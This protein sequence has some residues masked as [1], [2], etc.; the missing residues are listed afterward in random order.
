M[1]EQEAVKALRDDLERCRAQADALG[2]VIVALYLD[3]SL[4]EFSD[5]VA[6]YDGG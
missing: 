1:S 5:V 2:L 4:D 3:K 6:G